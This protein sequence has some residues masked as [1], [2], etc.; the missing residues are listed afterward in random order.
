MSLIVDADFLAAALIGYQERRKD[1]ET[2]IGELRQRIGGQPVSA[3]P[4]GAT[5]TDL[6]SSY[7]SKSLA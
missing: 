5:P 4:P 3:A 7:S 6:R 1:I 2:R